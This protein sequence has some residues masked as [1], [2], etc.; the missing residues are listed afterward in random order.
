[1]GS[2]PRF[3]LWDSLSE[4]PVGWKKELTR[5]LAV[6]RSVPYFRPPVLLQGPGCDRKSG[7]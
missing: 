1:M 6:E 7:I 2:V 3:P 4:V 5:P